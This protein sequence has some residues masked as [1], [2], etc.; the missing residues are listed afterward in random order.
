MSSRK[1]VVPS[2]QNVRAPVQA[3]AAIALA[4]IPL[5]LDLLALLEPTE[6]LGQGNGRRFRRTKALH[7]ELLNLV[8]ADASR[9]W[10][11]SE[12]NGAD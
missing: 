11:T 6:E 3:Q 7:F 5:S 2:G 12:E 1:S 10:L 8:A 9:R 4:P